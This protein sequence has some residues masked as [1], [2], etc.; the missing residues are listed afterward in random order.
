MIG[1]AC[2]KFECPLNCSYRIIEF[3]KCIKLKNGLCSKGKFDDV[4]ELTDFLKR[5][6]REYINEHFKD[7]S[8][9]FSEDGQSKLLSL[10]ECFRLV[11]NVW[12]IKRK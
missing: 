1:I 12:R 11:E 10:R 5:A 9:L 2:I 4:E 3:G 7:K 8:G 6:K